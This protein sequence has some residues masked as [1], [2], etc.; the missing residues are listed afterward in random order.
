MIKAII[1][2]VDGVIVGNQPNVNFPL[3]HTDVIEKF[4]ELHAK[5][6]PVVLCTAKS[7]FAIH[8]IIEQAH[9]DNPH[10][11]D[12]GALIIGLISHAIVKKHV[13]DKEVVRDCIQR[14]LE[15]NIFIE[16][17][18]PEAYYVQASQ[19]AAFPEFI[20]EHAKVLQM[21][22]TVTESL[23][24]QVD[25]EAIIKLI[26]FRNKAVGSEL[27]KIIE[28]FGQNVSALM[29]HHLFI[30]ATLCVM[31]APGIS[32]TSAAREVATS[33]NISF[34][35]ILGI[36]DTEGDWKFMH[37]CKY[38]ATLANGD[39]R[40]KELVRT[41]G[42]GNYFIAPHVNDNGMLDILRYFSL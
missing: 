18:T 4:R 24:G 31:T 12:G 16:V 7:G 26:A 10:I 2:D 39:D 30:D 29:T 3:P 41:K 8:G 34:D 11:T 25:H 14:C 19:M 5:G 22:P 9:L 33:L 20:T 42:E 21:Q 38:V 40:I 1:L 15:S 27:D 13:M 28:R 37:L 23:L 35:E 32:K 6:M 17:Y 36:G